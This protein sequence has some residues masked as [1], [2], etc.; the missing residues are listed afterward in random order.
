MTF[1][2]RQV[3]DMSICRRDLNAKADTHG[4][5]DGIYSVLQEFDAASELLLVEPCPV[6]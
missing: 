1:W 2:R 5:S 4:E 6:V 3:V